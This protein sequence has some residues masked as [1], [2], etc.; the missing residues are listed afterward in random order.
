MGNKRKPHPSQKELQEMFFYDRDTG[1]LYWKIRPARCIQWGS[2]AGNLTTSNYR[3]VKIGDTS[4]Q[5]HNLVW[6]YHHGEIPHDLTVDHRNKIPHDNRLSNLR[7]ANDRQQSI[8]RNIRGFRCHTYSKTW[9]AYHAINGKKKFIG[10]FLT[11]LQARLA[12]ERYTSELEPDFASTWLTD[13]VR[14]F[15]SGGSPTVWMPG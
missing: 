14:E 5:Q 11:A 2:V 15:C 10:G 13:A 12:Y 7:L 6:I 9:E 4:Y 8:N 3:C 1:L